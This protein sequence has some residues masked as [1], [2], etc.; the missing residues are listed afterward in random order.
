[1]TNKIQITS[2]NE[3]I[4]QISGNHSFTQGDFL[5]L[6]NN[7]NVKFM[8][9]SAS[10]NTAFCLCTTNKEKFLVGSEV[11]PAQENKLV[12]TSLE[13]FGKIIDIHGNIIFPIGVR[14][15]QFL[16]VQSKT[17]QAENDLMVYQTLTEQLNTGYAIVDLLIPLGKGQ[18][19]LIIG[20]RQTG[21]S[22]IALNTIIN[23]KDKNVKCIY[24]AIGQTQNQVSWVY[25]TLKEHNALDYTIIVNASPENPFEQYLAPYIGMAHAENLSYFD[26]VLIVFDD[27]TKH[28]N[29]YR[30]IALLT[31]KPIGKEAYPG[32]M[33][34]AHARLLE[35]SGRF[36]G[37]KSISALPILQTIDNDIT[38]LIASNV[39]SITDGQIVTS[40]ELFA[41]NKYPAINIDLSVSRIGTRLQK[42]IISQ[43]TKTIN[44]IYRAFKRQTKLAA[45]KYD[46]NEEV[47]NLIISGIQIEKLFNQ[48]GITSYD[49]YDLFL[50]SQII[51]FNI[52]NNLKENQMQRAIEFI[53]KFVKED[54]VSTEL[55][56]NIIQGKISDKTAPKDYFSF[57]LKTYSDMH[58]LNWNIVAPKEYLNLNS[59]LISKIHSSFKGAK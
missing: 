32:D 11:L 24:V 59:A 6:K 10:L 51:Q 15:S 50:T 28:A 56:N 36:V 31:K 34:Y 40:S 44:T 5:V 12:K 25:Q 45:L 57:L 7:P 2:I 53:I 41:L 37:R 49:E 13:Y 29:V 22:F 38:S 27:L 21:K 4:V 20:D 8:V 23:Q 1:M 26:D 54:K 58:N 39:I 16:D 43:T 33:F 52:L 19:E 46:L 47:N 35:R 3:Y 42:P 17:I 30:E 48:K 9:I 18:R 14:A 55:I